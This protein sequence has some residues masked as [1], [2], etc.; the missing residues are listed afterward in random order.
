MRRALAL[1]FLS[2]A[3]ATADETLVGLRLLPF[4]LPPN[5]ERAVYLDSAGQLRETELRR[6]HT[7]TR[8]R[9]THAPELRLYFPPD[10]ALEERLRREQGL[11]EGKK[12]VVRPDQLRMMASIRCP[13]A[14]PRVMAVLFATD[15]GTPPLIGVAAPDDG[16]AFP[17]GSYRVYN[18]TQGEIGGQVGGRAVKIGPISAGQVAAP[19]ARDFQAKLHHITKA[20]ERLP[21]LEATW[22]IEADER[23]VLFIYEDP[24]SGRLR[25]QGMSEPLSAVDEPEP[26]AGKPAKGTPP[27]RR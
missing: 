10:A 4:N 6:N 15:T 1:L 13:Q 7:G 8:L 22:R 18:L 25:F 27:V 16:S 14:G 17:A 11:P 3:A 24:G 5:C 21:L 12:P 26:E 19:T 20:G 2:A 23:R 9:L